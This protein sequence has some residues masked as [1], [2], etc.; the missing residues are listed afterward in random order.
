MTPDEAISW[1]RVKGVEHKSAGRE[2]VGEECLAG[3]DNCRPSLP[4]SSLLNLSMASLGLY[5]A[6]GALLVGALVPIVAGSR[7]SLVV[8]WP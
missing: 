8:S 6:Y 3:D 7:S 4:L 2:G 5:R 1:M